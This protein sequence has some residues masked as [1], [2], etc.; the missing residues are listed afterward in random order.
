MPIDLLSYLE[1]HTNAPSFTE[2]LRAVNE[3]KRHEL[4]TMKHDSIG[5][6]LSLVLNAL[7]FPLICKLQSSRVANNETQS[8]CGWRDETTWWTMRLVNLPH[9]DYIHVAEDQR[10]SNP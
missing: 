4:E 10:H 5:V 9:T 7:A 2:G 8:R 1:V 3:S 6:A